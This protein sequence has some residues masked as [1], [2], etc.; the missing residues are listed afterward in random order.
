MR[1]NSSV[2]FSRKRERAENGGYLRSLWRKKNI[3]ERIGAQNR[4]KNH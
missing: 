2:F 4:R 3:Y 1:Q